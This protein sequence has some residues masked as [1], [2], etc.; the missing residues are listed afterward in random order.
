MK[1]TGKAVMRRMSDARFTGRWLVG[2]GIDIGAGNDSLNSYQEMFPSMQD[3]KSWDMKDGDAQ[4]MAG[5]ED[6]SYD[7]VH[8]SHCLEH[9]H[10]PGEALKNW[11][12][13][14]KPG[15]HMVCLIPDED[16]YEQGTFPSTKNA[17]H[18]VTFTI[19]KSSSWSDK[20]ISLVDFLPRNL[21]DAQLLKLELLDATYRY[22][23]PVFDQTMTPLGECAIEFVL[24][25]PTSLDAINQG[26][27][28]HNKRAITTRDFD[29]LTYLQIEV[30][31]DANGNK[32][33]YIVPLHSFPVS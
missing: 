29:E 13:I 20:S 7:F 27:L 6:E 14:L 30:K 16:M 28:P 10:D 8:S 32:K 9:M 18:K 26:R 22:D 23:L 1:E 31:E 4:K 15:G 24:R 5:V 25:K 33:A 12:R 17:D 2:S 21:P 11:Y 3:C 19:A